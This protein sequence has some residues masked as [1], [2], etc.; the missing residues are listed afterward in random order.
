MVKKSLDAN[1]QKSNAVRIPIPFEY[2]TNECHLAF[3]CTDPVFKWSITLNMC[4]QASGQ[5]ITLW[6]RGVKI[7]HA[8]ASSSVRTKCIW[9][10]TKTS[11]MRRSYASGNLASLYLRSKESFINQ[12]NPS[13]A[14][15]HQKGSLYLASN[16]VTLI[17]NVPSIFSLN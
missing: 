11:K 17:V 9:D 1:G 15:S 3:L 2:W 12:A 14:S 16:I 5:L 6:R 4:I 7:L 8:S 13:S 10:P